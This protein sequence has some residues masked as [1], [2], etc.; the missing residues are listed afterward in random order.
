MK[1]WLFTLLFLLYATPVFAIT[2]GISTPSASI[3]Q[4]QELSLDV[5]LSCSN[6]SDSYLR[7]VF[8]ETGDNYFG[9]TQNN[10]GDWTGTSSDRTK[11]WKVAKDEIKDST[12]SGKVKVKVDTDNSYY[13]G[14]GSYSLKVGRYTSS[15]GSSATW[16]DSYNINITGPTPTPTPNPT[17]TPAPNPTNT[18]V[19]PTATVVPTKVPT[20]TRIPTP[21]PT[22]TPTLEVIP[23]GT[24]GGEVL[25]SEHSPTRPVIVS[26]LLV[27]AGL[28]LLAFVWVW[29]HRDVR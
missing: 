19:P 9:L 8:F 12:W 22:L 2:V 6:C 10:N 29:K 17:S 1:W 7:G 26:F 24:P 16:S 4:S 25:G 5:F 3:D 23:T 20:P 15:V 13:K 28:A 18:P 11:Y 14:S 21:L 27:S